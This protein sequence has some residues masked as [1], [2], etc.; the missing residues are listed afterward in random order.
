MRIG[1]RNVL[2]R[3]KFMR[4]YDEAEDDQLPSLAELRWRARHCAP[5]AEVQ[6][7]QDRAWRA[8]RTKTQSQEV[9]D[10]GS[11]ETENDDTGWDGYINEQLAEFAR[12]CAPRPTGLA[13]RRL[14][15]GE[16]MVPD[17]AQDQ[18][19]PLRR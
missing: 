3:A 5:M 7:R 4:V 8:V 1:R 6:A 15:A 17:A 10:H 12:T 9:W 14:A 2:E 13:E 18:A 16:G 11:I 19:P